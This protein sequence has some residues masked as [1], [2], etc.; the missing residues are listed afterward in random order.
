MMFS[1]APTLGKERVISHPCGFSHQAV[2]CPPSS[3]M[4]TPSFRKAA[5]CRS[6]GRGPSSQPPGK[7]MRALPHRARIG[8]R[9]ITEERISRMR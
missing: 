3:W 9:K 8:P 5:R 7:V 4:A 1:V 6:M 2:I